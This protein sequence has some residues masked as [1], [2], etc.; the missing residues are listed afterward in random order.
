MAKIGGMPNVVFSLYGVLLEGPGPEDRQRIEAAAGVEDPEAFWRVYSQLRPEYE[1]GLISDKQWWQKV[2]NRAGLVEFSIAEAVAADFG[3][4]L[5]ANEDMVAY[6]EQLIDEGHQVGVLANLPVGL[7]RLVR[8]KHTWLGDLAAVAMS[9][10]IGVAKPDPRAYAVAVDALGA[11]VKDTL[12]FDANPSWVAGAREVGLR[13]YL[14]SG[15]PSV[16]Q[17]LAT[18][19]RKAPRNKR[20]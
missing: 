10:D 13:S 5:D 1:A 15:V 17:V 19:P 2:A 3:A 6:A 20:G 14:I 4:R 8:A 12:Y 16:K 11:T 18:E 7:A 9:C